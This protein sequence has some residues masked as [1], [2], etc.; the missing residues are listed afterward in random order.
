MTSFDNY[1]HREP[2]ALIQIH[3]RVLR[4]ALIAVLVVSIIAQSVYSQIDSQIDSNGGNPDLD[5]GNSAELADDELGQRQ[6]ALQWLERMALA[7]EQ[8]NYRGSF[9]Y[10][11]GQVVRMLHV[12]HYRDHRGVRERLYSRDH[13]QIE[14]LR[15]NNLVQ[16]NS[17]ARRSD[18]ILNYSQF[19]RLPA[20]HLLDD[21]SHYRFQFGGEQ[22]IAGYR[23]QYVAIL[24]RDS[25]RY[26]FEY[27][28]E[29]RTGMLLQQRLLNS[30]GEMLEKLLFTDI[31]IGQPNAD[32]VPAAPELKSRRPSA[33]SG[34][35]VTASSARA[36]AGLPDAAANHPADS[37]QALLPSAD[38]LSELTRPDAWPDSMLK[39]DRTEN[40]AAV[41]PAVA[42][43]EH[44]GEPAWQCVNPPRGY[45]L[46][47]HQQT[48]Q[49]DGAM[50]DHLLYSDGLSQISV[51]IE[52]GGSAAD[53]SGDADQELPAG[54]LGIMNVYRR[55]LDNVNITA[56]G[57]A[58]YRTLRMLGGSMVQL[59]AAAD[60]R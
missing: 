51:Y 30:A 44:R 47:A 16:V 50:T 40:A 6:Q 59:S 13:Q 15:N 22:E 26:G 29:L 57:A 49:P 32:E 5:A 25:L 55:Q 38:E 27:W 18:P 23:A 8:L 4:A 9:I 21:S 33:A 24:P 17:S 41:R 54:R 39:H 42:A 53:Q 12:Q 36:S 56:L 37:G 60:G 34:L 45:T 1:Y 35:L 46:V 20:S 7:V 11:Q 58:P 48:R 52:Q 28:L 3:F 2:S 10:Q 14:I 31:E 43:A 19:T